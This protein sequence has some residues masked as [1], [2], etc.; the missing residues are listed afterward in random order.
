M[1]PEIQSRLKKIPEQDWYPSESLKFCPYCGASSLLWRDP[2]CAEC[3]HCGKRLYMN[4]AAATLAIIEDGKGGILCTKRAFDPGKGLLDLPGGFADPG[5]TFEQA[6]ARELKEELGWEV[7]KMR[8]FCSRPNVY[9]Y[10][11][12]IYNTM[13]TAFIV[14]T[15]V[16]QKIVQDDEILSTAFIPVSE[17]NP[18]DFAFD[19]IR[20]IFLLYR[21]MYYYNY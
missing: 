5:E 9:P 20:E 10:R 7:K 8:Y 18:D 11:G 4:A 1:N 12:M 3:E 21:Q 16:M 15:D 19:S 17:I 6:L 14:E 13:D 2:N